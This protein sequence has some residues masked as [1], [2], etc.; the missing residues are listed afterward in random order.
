[1][2]RLSLLLA[3][4]LCRPPHSLIPA[5]FRRR[6]RLPNGQTTCLVSVE[7][8]TR[9]SPESESRDTEPLIFVQEIF[10]YFKLFANDVE[11]KERAP[12]RSLL[13]SFAP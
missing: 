8:R 6:P 4:A 13:F 10:R 5:V 9:K 11:A 12:H 2:K 1:M 3:V 7:D